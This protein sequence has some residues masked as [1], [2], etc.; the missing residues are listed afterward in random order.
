MP[1]AFNKICVDC[2]QEYRGMK[3]SRYCPNCKRRRKAEAGKNGGLTNEAKQN[4]TAEQIAEK[5]G[6]N[7]GDRVSLR[8]QTFGDGH[9]YGEVVW[10][11][12]GRRYAVV[13]FTVQPKAPRWGALRPPVRLR[14]CFL[15]ARK[16]R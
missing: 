8:P 12:P 7:P 16:K 3:D 14:E 13:E 4:E 5:V 2:G 11:H 1:G 10:V 6:I 9:M 15:L